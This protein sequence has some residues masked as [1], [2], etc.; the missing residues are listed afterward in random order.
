[1]R[2]SIC[3]RYLFG[4]IIR[5]ERLFALVDLLVVL[6]LL[7]KVLSGKLTDRVIAESRINEWGPVP[8]FF[9]T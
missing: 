3:G 5:P 7:P 1:M 4:R 9:G 2:F 8:G 6:G